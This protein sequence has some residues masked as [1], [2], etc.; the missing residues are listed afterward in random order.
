MA[1]VNLA[2]LPFLGADKDAPLVRI[3]IKKFSQWTACS[4]K[5]MCEQKRFCDNV[6][7]PDWTSAD[8]GSALE[9]TCQERQASCTRV[10]APVVGTCRIFWA[11]TASFVNS[12][13]GQH[14]LKTRS[15][16]RV[17]SRKPVLVL[18]TPTRAQHMS[19]VTHN[20]IRFQHTAAKGCGAKRQSYTS[21]MT[22]RNRN[23]QNRTKVTHAQTPVRLESRMSVTWCCRA[24]EHQARGTTPHNNTAKSM[25]YAAMSK[26]VM[27]TPTWLKNR[28]RWA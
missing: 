14:T 15:D 10:T 25:A 23:A 6:M 22:V 2:S 8:P 1:C 11:S 26:N 5:N 4:A 24:P 12:H 28:P 16:L 19:A 3:H 18:R 17:I 13:F 27:K 21:H 9:K 20:A 7:G